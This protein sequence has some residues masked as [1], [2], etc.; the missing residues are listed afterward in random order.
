MSPAL[1][2]ILWGC[3]GSSTTPPG[4][5]DPQDSGP[6]GDTSAAVSAPVLSSPAEAEDLDPSEGVVE[7]LLTPAPFTHSIEDWRTGETLTVEGYAYNE[8]TPGPTIRA[9]KGD[10]LRATVVNDTDQPTTIHW[11]GVASPWEMDGAVWMID[12]IAP[13]ETF[14]YEVPLEV[15]GTFWYHP[16][17]DT[18]R[19]VDLGLYGVLIV[20][21]PDE[22][23]A[24]DGELVVVL[25]DWIDRPDE[26]G[27]P[28]EDDHG[29][30]YGEGLW[31]LNGLVQPQV[32]LESGA[33]VRL[34]LLQAANEGYT[35]LGLADEDGSTQTLHQVAADQGRLPTVSSDERLL[36]TPG[37]RVEVALLPGEGAL[38]LLDWPYDNQGG[39]AV[40][41]PAVLLEL[42]SSGSAS[43]GSIPTLGWEPVAPSED[44]GTTDVLWV[45]QGDPRTG[46]WFINGETFPDVTVEQL[47]LDQHA[48]IEVRNVS[49]TEHPFHLHGVHFEVLSINGEPP[50][51]RQLEDT[52]NIP[53]HGVARLAI[54]AFNPGYWMAHCHI[55]PHGDGGM[56]TVL[57]I[58]E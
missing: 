45:L 17:F 55:L 40:G 53:I 32:S 22:D 16:H 48:V 52:V 56:M 18:E 57:Q 13:G 44:P 30:V 41:D 4:D 27:E 25:D 21:D 6:S 23:G 39:E 2:A 37:D 58:G 26:V 7:V 24:F 47:Q 9:R 36:I 42:D 20:E 43:S 12:P 33:A 11:H 15:A 51:Q 29:L 28:D 46:S 31:T 49:P 14:T 19:Q 3:T 34:R 35:W 54:E 1:F 10:L 38:Q 5:T 50:A 8:Q